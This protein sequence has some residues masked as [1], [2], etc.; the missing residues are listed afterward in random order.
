MS[1]QTTTAEIRQSGVESED[2]RYREECIFAS[3][4]SAV[5]II[6]ALGTSGAA[7]REGPNATGP[8]RM[9]WIRNFFSRGPRTRFVVLKVCAKKPRRSASARGGAVR[10]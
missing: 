9:H 2:A 1:L 7:D 5:D 8:A 6:A 3:C 10:A 4:M